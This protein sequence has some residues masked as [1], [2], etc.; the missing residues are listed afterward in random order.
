MNLRQ[1]L[2]PIL[3]CGFRPFF[4]LATASACIFMLAWLLLLGGPFGSWQPP[5][6][7]VLW[8]AH[9]LLFG[10]GSAAVAGFALTAIPEFTATREFTGRPLAL[11]VLAWLLA[12][13]G[14]L[15]ATCWPTV[16]GLWPAAL[17]NLAFWAGLLWLL[18]PR[19]WRDP[20]RQH[21]SF[22]W[23]M[24]ALAALQLGFFIAV[25]L[26][27]E[28]MAWLRAATGALMMLIVVATS[29]I[30][31]SVVNGRIEEGRPGAAAPTT[32]YLAR[33]PRRYL[34]MFCIGV[35][36]ATEFAL[37]P[38]NVT[39]W[40]ALAAAAAMF[41]LLNDW[42]IGR[43]LLSRW[44]LML[45]GSYWLIALGY[46]AMGAAWL[47]APF[48]PSSGRHL[49][50]SGALSLAVF[51]VMAMVGRIHAGLWLD[52][53]PW[54]PLCA[55]MLVVAALLRAVAGMPFAS[56]ASLLLLGL[57]GLLWACCFAVYLGYAWSVLVRPRSDGQQGCAGPLTPGQRHDAC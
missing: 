44:A 54:V 41:N 29:R 4:L 42:H 35:C 36:S 21:L 23:V 55:V 48:S 12:R 13:L 10:F 37:G 53:R 11:L 32:S 30:S 31:M 22:A 40:T 57:S 24:A 7:I 27:S 9:E 38:G 47:G 34:A 50:T 25:A 49:L 17:L 18:G 45:Y 5:G 15:L 56:S 46:A 3:S 16:L 26:E 1:W 33:P 14:Y 52:R 2:Q 19:L 8:H 51:V 6:G 28:A 43:S 20:G 39:G